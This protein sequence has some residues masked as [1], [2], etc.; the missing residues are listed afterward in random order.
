MMVMLKGC[1]FLADDYNT[2]EEL[3]HIQ[4]VRDFH[5]VSN[6]LHFRVS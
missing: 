5:M 3:G 2:A 4:R 1:N 6:E